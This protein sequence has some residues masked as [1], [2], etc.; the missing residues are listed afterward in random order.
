MQASPRGRRHAAWASRLALTALS[1]GA[2]TLGLA[3]ESAE[4]P[5]A[6]R[7]AIVDRAIEH[8][9]GD[10]YTASEVRLSLC[11]KSGCSA[12]RA[13]TDGWDFDLEATAS[14]SVSWAIF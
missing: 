10:A 9:G 4:A 2:S 11:S 8:H 7:L 1:V 3:A 6:E 5:R 14:A 12:I 13:L